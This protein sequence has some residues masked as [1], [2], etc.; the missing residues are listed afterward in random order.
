M[1]PN[2][3][4]WFNKGPS[5]NNYIKATGGTISRNGNWLIHTFTS[6][7]NFTIT[8]YPENA[9]LWVLCI[10]GGGAGAGWYSGGSGGAGGYRNIPGHTPSLGMGTYPIV[11]GTGGI[12]GINENSAAADGTKGGNSSFDTISSAGGGAGIHYTGSNTTLQNGGSGGSAYGDL[13]AGNNPATLPPQGY[14]GGVGGFLSGNIYQGSGGGALRAGDTGIISGA[15]GGLGATNYMTGSAIVYSTGGAGNSVG[16]TDGLSGVNP[17]DGGGGS[18]TATGLGGNGANGIIR[19]A[20]YSPITSPTTIG[21]LYSFTYAA[22]QYDTTGTV[23]TTYTPGVSVRL[24]N[25]NLNNNNNFI[26]VNNY[27]SDCGNSIYSTDVQFNSLGATDYGASL[28]IHSLVAGSIILRVGAATGVNLGVVEVYY[29]NILLLTLGTLSTINIG[30]IINYEIKIIDNSVYFKVIRL[31]EVITGSYTF[32]YNYTGTPKYIP[33]SYTL[34]FGSSGG[35]YLFTNS[36]FST[37]DKRECDL[38]VT[39]DSRPYGLFVTG[40]DP[41]N[42]LAG[43][44]QTANPDKRVYN[45]TGPGETLL[46]FINRLPEIINYA[47]R[48]LD[49]IGIFNDVAGG[50]T[51]AQIVGNFNTILYELENRGIICWIQISPISGIDQSAA[52]AA[53]AASRPDIIIPEPATWNPVTDLSPDGGHWTPSGNNK[54]YINQT[55]YIKLP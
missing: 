3:Q 36:S 50:R 37:L 45:S 12:G 29:N 4:W 22:A 24:Q 32:D 16:Q 46:N 26:Y 41:S 5:A 51:P 53:V 8:K 38:M 18:G 52:N 27:F 13:V 20:Y 55:T 35:D 7:D 19:I 47:P 39:L 34:G 6:N 17:G 54:I 14:G 2:N 23:T 11:V 1:I 31:T 49:I 43:L 15:L 48:Q 33:P 44:W 10:G 28:R 42:R 9:L 21:S 30:D 25:T 40:T